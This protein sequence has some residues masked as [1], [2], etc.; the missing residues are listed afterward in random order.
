MGH[1]ETGKLSSCANVTALFA[2]RGR[3]VLTGAAPTNRGG[4]E[5]A[6]RERHTKKLANLLAETI[7]KMSDKELIELTDDC[8]FL[9][10]KNCWWLEMDL[11]PVIVELARLENANRKN[12]AQP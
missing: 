4:W 11:K 6:K 7:H 8:N 10:N 2:S 5:M 9:T 3:V 12:E 1:C